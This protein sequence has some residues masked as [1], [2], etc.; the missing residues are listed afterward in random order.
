MLKR[1]LFL[2]VV[3]LLS[4]SI[5]LSA[6]MLNQKQQQTIETIETETTVTSFADWVDVYSSVEELA[7]ATDDIIIGKLVDSYVW[8]Y[9]QEYTHSPLLF[10]YYTVE[11]QSIIKGEL[12]DDVISVYVD[13][14]IRNGVEYII[15]DSPLLNV[16]DTMI[17]FL[18][19]TPEEAYTTRGGPQGRF[20]I[21]NGKVYATDEYE[22]K[23]NSLTNRMKTNT[24][25]WKT[26]LTKS[27]KQY[28]LFFILRTYGSTSTTNRPT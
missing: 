8:E 20:K 19:E 26:S 12:A 9:P 1:K 15:E 21:V 14:G 2:S 3:V 5:A 25:N 11:V 17:L 13:G 23:D 10:T 18:W 24:R 7:K 28:F 22:G 4:I 6:F 16:N 27:H